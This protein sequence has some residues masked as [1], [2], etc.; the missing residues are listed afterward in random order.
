MR[1]NC[2][3]V[4]TVSVIKVRNQF[5]GVEKGCTAIGEEIR[6]AGIMLSGEGKE[7]SI[8]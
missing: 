1:S 5:A 2:G 4:F 7:G 6:K 8:I 3:D